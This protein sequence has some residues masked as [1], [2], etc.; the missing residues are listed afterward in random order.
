MSANCILDVC[1]HRK[2]VVTG[3]RLETG[4]NTDFR[5]TSTSLPSKALGYVDCLIKDAIEIRLHP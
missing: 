2:A 5:S 1:Q 4:H 3:H